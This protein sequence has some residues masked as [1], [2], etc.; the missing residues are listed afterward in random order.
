MDSYYRNKSTDYV[1]IIFGWFF[2]KMNF[3]EVD[4][5]AEH[6]AVCNSFLWTEAETKQGLS[7]VHKS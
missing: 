5:K 2:T 7:E 3:V 6:L 4:W 1:F